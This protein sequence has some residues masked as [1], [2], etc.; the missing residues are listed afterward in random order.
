MTP[1]EFRRQGH[2]AVE[3]VAS[4]LE[5]VDDLPVAST[6]RP[7]DVRAR[8]PRELPAGG[9]S[10][11]AI[12]RDLDDIILPGITHWQSPNF[13]AYF[14]ANT[15]GPAILGEL[16]SAGL[17]V[18]GM[19]WATSPAATELEIHIMDWLAEMLDLPEAFRSTG[20]GG[21]VIEGSASESSLCAIVAAR[22][23]ATSYATNRTGF[24]ESLV[25]YCSTQTHSSVEKGIRIAG[26]GSDK[27][28]QIEVDDTFALRPD[29]LEAAIVADKAAGLH[30]FLVIATVGTTSSTAIDPLPAIGAICKRHGLWLHVD[31]AYGGTAAV[32]PEFRY[33]NAGIEL[34]D[35]YVFDPHKW[36]F[37]GID[38]SCFFVADRDALTHA[39]TILPEY[40]RNAATASGEVIDYRDWQIP[41][42][43]R[44]RS[45]KLWMMLRY[46]GVE[47][48]R[49]AVRAHVALAREFLTWVQ[50]DDRFEV[51][52]PAPLNLIC[53]RY[54]G[55][56]QQP[57]AAGDAANQ[58]IMDRVN[59]SG[60]CFISHTKLAG[61][62]TLRMCVG[63]EHTERRHVEQA[64][65]LIQEAADHLGA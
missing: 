23:K 24:H 47:G 1:D 14:P 37:G 6:V 11:D 32:C 56:S 26:I 49:T 22:E 58:A 65:R 54:K 46:Y 7:G 25:A 2:A 53:F 50:A 18:Q 39:L 27:L 3:W 38:S 52:A 17:N 20:T 62:L 12:L 45:L 35:S 42:G 41:L 16:L 60:R 59:A 30:P 15:S 36:M 10:I 8:L 44:F 21:G 43:H 51:A 4:Y 64:W 29:L 40:L 5:R 31:A 28:R 9:D 48:L 55:L 13:F 61:R 19:L 57:D 34:V 63:Q 33:I